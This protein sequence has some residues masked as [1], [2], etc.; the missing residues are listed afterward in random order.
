[1]GCGDADMS[2]PD[3]R[4]ETQS[5]YIQNQI[6]VLLKSVFIVLITSSRHVTLSK[7]ASTE[8]VLFCSLIIRIGHDETSLSP[9]KYSG[10]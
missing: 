4:N 2:T 7:R 9:E 10:M 6:L 1:M 5:T 8:A 3:A